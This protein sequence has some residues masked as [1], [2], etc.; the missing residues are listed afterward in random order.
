M[1]FHF[2]PLIKKKKALTYIDETIMQSQNKGEMF[3]FLDEYHELLRKTDGKA[4]TEKT[5]SSSK[6]EKFW[7]TSFHLKDYIQSQNGLKT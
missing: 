2:K 3:S 1:T 7:D 6:Q 5:F 4:A